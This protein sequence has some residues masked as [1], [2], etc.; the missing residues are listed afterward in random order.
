M[1]A[2]R[3]SV[4]IALGGV[5]ATVVF[6]GTQPSPARD[7]ATRDDTVHG[8]ALFD[9]AAPLRAR[10][11]S[12][13]AE[14]PAAVVRCANC[15]AAGSGPAVPNSIAP[16][17]SRGWLVEWQSRRGGPPSRYDRDAFCTLLRDGLDPAYVLIN[18]QMPRYRVDARDCTALWQFLS[19]ARDGRA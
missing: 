3:G 2:Y 6:A 1:R 7:A 11:A 17:L 9:G 19:G 16:R 15:H 14:L 12:H 18:V 4:L 8:Q 5:L 13:P 10:L